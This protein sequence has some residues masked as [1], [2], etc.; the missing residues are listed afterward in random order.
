[1]GTRQ[2]QPTEA[3]WLRHKTAIGRLYLVEE[4]P[5]KELVGEVRNLGLAVT[6]AQL[7]YK[8]KLWGFRRN[9]SG[10][11]WAIINHRIAKREREGKDSQVVYRGRRLE[12]K[13]V[14]K[15]R[16]R[17]CYKSTLDKFVPGLLNLRREQAFM[18]QVPQGLCS[19]P[20]LNNLS[21]PGLQMTPT[22]THHQVIKLAVIMRNVM[23]EGYPGEHTERAQLLLRGSNQERLQEYLKIL[24]YKLSNNH[25]DSFNDEEWRVSM[26]ILRGANLLDLKI[27]LRSSGDITISGFMTNMF[28]AAVQRI[29]DNYNINDYDDHSN[30]DDD[31][32]YDDDCTIV[33]DSTVTEAL[34]AVRWLLSMGQNPNIRMW[35][36]DRDVAVTPLQSATITGCLDLVKLLLQKGADTSPI[37]D[38]ESLSILDSRNL[39]SPLEL[40]L[41]EMYL[42][43][44]IPSMHIADCLLDHGASMD[45]DH[46]LHLAIQ[47][48]HLNIADRLVQRGADLCI[49]RQKTHMGAYDLRSE[50]TAMSVAAKV[51]KEATEFVLNR[52]ELDSLEKMNKIITADVFISAA[53]EGN[54]DVIRL[55]YEIS[56]AN[57]PFDKYGL[58]PLHAAAK[59][60]HLSTCR[61]L[62]QLWGPC[63]EDVT[64]PSPIHLASSNG[65]QD[66]VRFFIEKGADIDSLYI[67]EVDDQGVF[68]WAWHDLHGNDKT[69]KFGLLTPLQLA[70]MGISGH[71]HHNYGTAVRKIGC[72][73]LLIEMGAQLQGGE[74]VLAASEGHHG[75]LST[76]L[77]AGGDPNEKSDD[78]TTALQWTLSSSCKGSLHDQGLQ[79]TLSSSCKGSLHDQVNVMA[80]VELFFKQGA[81][82]VGGEVALA[83]LSGNLDLA[84]LII[85]HGGNLA[86]AGETGI[87]A[88]EAAILSQ[89]QACIDFMLPPWS[90]AYDSG[91]LCAAIETENYSC[92]W[93]LLDNRPSHS[94][95][96]LDII[97]TT[98]IA[99]AGGSGDVNI[100]RKLLENPPSMNTALLP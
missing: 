64:R 35:D 4:M 3:E 22:D 19:W 100:L 48:Q 53:E 76:A 96:E 37:S 52:L 84:A 95:V 94:R 78:G 33:G 28:R 79:W 73:I 56:S 40:S 45:W 12:A 7:E 62:L 27:D 29:R 25:L 88:L 10:A 81:I 82:L 80:I 54:D 24:F 46:A 36:K 47:R 31:S 59:H 68:Q 49:A 15:E 57:L 87:T 89:N 69:F 5:L 17:H 75:L 9:I 98:A 63:P 38:P 61:L 21:A 13:T 99:L 85:S 67:K 23:P 72:G 32:D 77:G 11:T 39:P 70:L 43:Q 34:T 74:V 97:E 60:G 30:Y 26:D 91:A 55:L 14:E 2:P 8:L 41:D 16:K 42:R 58:T 51:G 86:D 92:A 90:N 1:M 6:K 18:P 44:Q 20:I 93:Q 65:H 71:C 66:V 83:I 50:E